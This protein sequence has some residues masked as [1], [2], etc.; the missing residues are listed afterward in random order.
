VLRLSGPGRV[1]W[2]PY[3]GERTVVVLCDVDRLAE[4][5]SGLCDA[6]RL[7]ETPVAVTTV[8]TTTDQRT[9][10]STLRSVVADV[11]SAE[12]TSSAVVVVG[13]VVGLRDTL[14]WFETKPLFGW[15]VL[16]PRTKEQ[17]GELSARLRAHGAVPQEV[18]TISVEPPRNPSRWTRPSADWSRVDTSGSPSPRPTPCVPC[19]RS[20]TSTDWTRERSPG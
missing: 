4:A 12:L 14:S 10:T 2:R 3:A 5:V 15:R 6:G 8:G 18:P 1:D 16:V 17:A 7:D 19:A 20:S 11:A 9:V 13:E